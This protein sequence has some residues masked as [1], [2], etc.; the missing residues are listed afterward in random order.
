MS[1]LIVQIGDIHFTGSNDKALD[2]AENIGAT[3]AQEI[4]MSTSSVLLIYSGD[5]AYSGQIQQFELAAKFID[6]IEGE[7]KDR[8]SFA[9]VFS[10]VVPG[11]H[12]CDFSEDKDKRDYLL[13]GIGEEVLKDTS[14]LNKIISSLNNY[15]A[16][17]EKE[18]KSDFAISSEFPLYK[19]VDMQDGEL[20]VR[21][22]F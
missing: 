4:H 6:R 14:M 16:F 13:D 3:I 17:I 19:P 5:L 22:H 9:D 11:N 15:F 7:I 20:M 18:S 21:L 12:D 8:T 1:V 10:I 2:R